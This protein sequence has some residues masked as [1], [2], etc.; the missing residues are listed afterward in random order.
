VRIWIINHYA[1]SA[2]AVGITRHYNFAKQLILRGHEVTIIAADY[3]HFSH[4]YVVSSIPNGHSNH[5]DNVPFIWIPTPSYRGNTMARLLNML[6]FSWRILQ[7]KYLPT[8]PMPDIIMGSSPHLFAALSAHFLARRLK[9][10]F[11]L[12]IRD[13][14][15]ETLVD[16]KRFSKKHP[17]VRVMKW[18][19]LFLYRR[20]E[21]IISLLPAAHEY[22]VQ[23]GVKKSRILFL[24]NSIDT[25]LI[26]Q[27]IPMTRNEKFTIIYAGSHGFA[28]DLDTVVTAAKILQKKGLSSRIRICLIGDGPEKARLKNIATSQ[29]LSLLEFLDPVPKNEIYSL[30]TKADAFL[31]LLKNLPI[32]RWGISP[33]K[34]FDYMAIGRPVIFAVNTPY[35]PISEANAGVSIN[36]SDPESLADAID[37]ISQVSSPILSAMGKRGRDFVF[38]NHNL[39]HQ[40]EL[41]ENLLKEVIKNNQ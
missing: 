2:N 40:I 37:K 28:N 26:P 30:L 16:T 1:V 7:K 9:K 17:L 31:M 15:P 11:I 24:P 10:P 12:E 21:R 27:L 23:S 34:L 13:L 35:N 32:F 14:W 41:L 18:I 29:N 22:L 25:T 39:L 36:S 5:S 20:A 4:S 33:N 19:E 38:K 6:I 3:N 8:A